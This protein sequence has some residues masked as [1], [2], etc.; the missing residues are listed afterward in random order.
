LT[1]PQKISR[2]RFLTVVGLA[3]VAGA[4]CVGFG[5]AW[6][7]K[8][9]DTVKR[10]AYAQS[11]PT[12]SNAP[13]GPLLEE[14]LH[15]LVATAETLAGGPVQPNHYAECFRWRS[16]NVAGHKH[17][18]EEFARVVNQAANE[19]TGCQFRRCDTPRRVNILKTVIGDGGWTRVYDRLFRRDRIRFKRYILDPILE[20]FEATDGW[21]LLGYESWPG[22]PRGLDRYTQAPNGSAGRRLS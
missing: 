11:Q 5:R 13:T 20:L 12:L 19:A 22:I 1:Q 4:V 8:L 3:G 18:Y 21:V 10:F 2:R 15:V 7:T 16:E 9:M 14:A 17:L 6:G